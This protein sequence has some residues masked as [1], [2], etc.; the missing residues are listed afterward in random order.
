MS[1][2]I[3]YTVIPVRNRWGLTR[4]C[5]ESLLKQ[6]Y[7]RVVAIVVD[8]GSSDGTVEQLAQE[9]PDVVVLLGDGD[10]WWTGATARGVDWV[11][12]HCREGDFVLTLNN[13]TT[14]DADYISTLVRVESMFDSPS[15]VGSVAI[16]NRDCDTIVDGGPHVN[17]ST[18]KGGSH[19]A[20]HSLRTVRGN[21]LTMTEPDFL[22][23]RG[24]L[25][26]VSCF[27]QIGNFDARR[28]P[29]YAADYE[30]SARARRA[31]YR[32]VMS[33]EAPVYSE[34]EATG[35][36]TRRGRLGW[37]EFVGMFFSRRS[38]ACLLYRWRFARLAAPRSLV[39]SFLVLDT[40]RV[41]FGGLRDQLSTWS[42]E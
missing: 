41:V 36:S 5:L 24:T 11:L 26:P 22:P 10:L 8:D 2:N 29:H 1:A 35:V 23:G 9:F 39:A 31:G 18:A 14:V 28:L 4:A 25:I 40:A 12:Q 33:Y 3:V 21:G 32:L 13:D 20:G 34:V 15:L 37:G 30:F 17:W 6:T 19:H 38:P 27:N 16:D 7:P 42:Q